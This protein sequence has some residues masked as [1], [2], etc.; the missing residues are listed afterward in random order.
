MQ[1]A[2]TNSFAPPATRILLIEDD[3]SLE[4]ILAACLQGDNVKIC[5]VRDGSQ[6]LLETEREDFD[7]I[8]LDMGLPGMDGFDLL[9]QLKSDPKAQS[10]PVIAL[11]AWQ[12]TSD[13]VRGLE[14][15]AVDYITKPFE[16]IGRA[17]C[18]E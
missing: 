14:L 11:T 6:A 5:N 12:S 4:E 7:L 10:I 15:G 3:P 18:R 1:S 9:A 8:L 2:E 13:K 16:Q 17:S